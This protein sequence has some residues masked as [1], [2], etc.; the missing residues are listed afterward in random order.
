MTVTRSNE[1]KIT[2]RL[3]PEHRRSLAFPLLCLRQS[4]PIINDFLA[5]L[6][7]MRLTLRAV[8]LEGAALAYKDTAGGHLFILGWF[9]A[10][11]HAHQR[12]ISRSSY[13]RA[14]NLNRSC[15]RWIFKRCSG[16]QHKKQRGEKLH[17]KR[18]GLFRCQ[19]VCVM[20][21]GQVREEG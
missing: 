6:A 13:S 20:V 10:E 1:G 11:Q 18:G 5:W 21:M 15:A 14:L 12:E 16:L 19:E 8:I 3:V 17:A 9:I 7:R 2:G 4:D